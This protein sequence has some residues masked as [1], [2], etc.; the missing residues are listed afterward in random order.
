M[1]TCNSGNNIDSESSFF[2]VTDHYNIELNTSQVTRY[3]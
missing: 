1:R 3:R 2:Q